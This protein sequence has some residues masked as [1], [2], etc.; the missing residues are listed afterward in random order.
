MYLTRGEKYWMFIR[1]GE[2]DQESLWGR[3]MTDIISAEGFRHWGRVEVIHQRAGDLVVFPVGWCHRVLTYDAALGV[4]GYLDP[5]FS[6]GS[7]A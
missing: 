5:R 6:T 7:L 4:G 3:T 1:E 2:A